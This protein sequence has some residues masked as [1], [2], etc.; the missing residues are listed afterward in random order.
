MHR[1]TPDADIYYVA[2]RTDAPQDVHARFRV[3]DK[4][5]ELW[6]PDTGRIEPAS[7]RIADDRT[8]VPLH[9][10]PRQSVFVV[11]RRSASSPM[12]TLP[13]R[14]GTALATVGG[15]W[16]VTFPPDLGAPKSIQLAALE[17]WTS[18]G[19]QGVKYFSGTATYTKTVTALQSWFHS[20]ARLVLDLGTVHDIAEV[21]VNGTPLAALWKPPYQVDVTDTL[22]PGD[23]H[24]QIKVTNQWTNRQRGDR[25]VSAD[26]KVL[27]T[28]AFTFGPPGR[29]PPPLPSGLLGPV[30]VTST[31]SQ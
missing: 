2:N 5:A 19:D 30:T 23:N 18:H 15:P 10:S 17:S 12:R 6:H 7:Y 27:P 11:F 22:E 3:A 24:L 26:Q 25:L 14:T 9:F 1:R 8:T 28:P 13:Q 21:S 20:G 4:E 16:D 31:V 29:T